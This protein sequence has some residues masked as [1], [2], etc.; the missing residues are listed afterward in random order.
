MIPIFKLNVVNW[1]KSRVHIPFY[2]PTNIGWSYSSNN[3]LVFYYNASGIII[4]W[5][6]NVE[7]DLDLHNSLAWKKQERERVAS[8]RG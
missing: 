7:V 8:S 4:P 2:T 5:P 6:L 1:K 3:E